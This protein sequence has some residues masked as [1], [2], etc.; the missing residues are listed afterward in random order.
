MNRI[1][2]MSCR[3]TIYTFLNRARLDLVA[4]GFLCARR[5]KL[6]LRRGEVAQRANYTWLEQDRGRLPSPD[7]LDRI[8]KGLLLTEAERE[9]LFMLALG[10][11]LEVRYRV[12]N[13]IT[14]RK[15][16]F[17]T[18]HVRKMQMNWNIQDLPSKDDQTLD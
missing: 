4:L 14:P 15:I 1:R 2:D 6:G 17:C 7:V 18:P 8:A 16:V 13:G 10:H 3:L 9:H 12:T 11:L 5:R